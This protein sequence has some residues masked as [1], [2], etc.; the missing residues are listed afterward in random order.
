[1]LMGITDVTLS[2]EQER[3]AAEVVASGRHRDVSEVEGAALDGLR[4]LERQR[5]E[6]LASVM[7][8][9]QE[10]GRDGF[11][12]GDEVAVRVRAT[13]A[14][15]SAAPAWAGSGVSLRRLRLIPMTRWVGCWTDRPARLVPGGCWRQCSEQAG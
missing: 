14:R 10:G 4:Q 7:A 8:A 3:C 13:I 5:A 2:P 12:T 9:G 15:R 1:M 11:L 6:L